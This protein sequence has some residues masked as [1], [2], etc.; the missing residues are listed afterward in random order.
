MTEMTP[1]DVQ[2]VLALRDA[3]T[4]PGR[5]V[6]YLGRSINDLILHNQSPPVVY[7]T[8][9]ARIAELKAGGASVIISTH[10][11]HELFAR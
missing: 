5:F 10:T 3:T 7:E 9:K 6:V 1:A 2:A 4:Y 11:R 8:K